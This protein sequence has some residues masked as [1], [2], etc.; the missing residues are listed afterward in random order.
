MTQKHK[1]LIV[2]ANIGWCPKKDVL[3]KI[4][5]WIRGFIKKI[6]IKLLTGPYKTYINEEGNI[7]YDISCF[8]KIIKTEYKLLDREI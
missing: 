7:R 3:N 8:F 4:S 6:N 5:D 1:Y 2:R